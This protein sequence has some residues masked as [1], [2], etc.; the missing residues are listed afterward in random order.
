MATRH[1]KAAKLFQKNREKAEWQDN[2]L[3]GVRVKRD[4]MA[5][6]LDEWETLRDLA[7]AI[8]KHTVSNL[9]IYLEQF[10]ENAEKNGI[11]VHWAKDAD[12]FNETVLDILK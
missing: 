2:T 8:K 12:E 4:R 7:S 10:A 6:S 1:S 9:D 3:W 11:I 5:K